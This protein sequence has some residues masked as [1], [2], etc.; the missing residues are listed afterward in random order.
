V[1]ALVWTRTSSPALRELLVH[2]RQAFTHSR[3]G[4]APSTGG[5]PAR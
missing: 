2:S 4:Q 3:A 1:L 5:R